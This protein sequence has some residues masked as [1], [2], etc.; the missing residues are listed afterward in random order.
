MQEYSNKE[1]LIAEIQK[2]YTLLAKEFDGIP[3]EKMNIRI[4]EVDRTPQEMIAYQ[5]GWLN[6][7]MGWEKDEL[8]GKKV[9]TPSPDYK[10]NQLGPLYQQF[11]TEYRGYSLQD[12]RA[13][14]QQSI[15]KWCAWIE[16]LS[17]EELFRPNMRKWT[18]TNANWPLWKWVHI[19]SVAPF[20]TF[21]T[22]LRKWKKLA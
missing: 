12:L 7:V 16:Q 17:D 3:E 20:R 11:Y 4:T 8:A 15:D 14:F 9:I 5:L 22:K 1:A 18:V 13:M 19:N 21:R 6:L 2:T 10:W